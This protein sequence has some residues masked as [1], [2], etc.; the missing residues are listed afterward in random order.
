ML[1][2]LE[3]THH[4]NKLASDSETKETPDSSLGPFFLSFNNRILQ[5][6][7]ETVLV[8]NKNVRMGKY[9][10]RFFSHAQN[11]TFHARMP[12]FPHFIRNQNV[13]HFTIFHACSGHRGEES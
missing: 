7:I 5:F 4:K 6:N 13:I 3:R 12:F 11:S 8:I 10:S 1:K 9:Y 2:E